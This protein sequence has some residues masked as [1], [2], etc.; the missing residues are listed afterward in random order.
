MKK[1]RAQNAKTVEELAAVKR[2]RDAATEGST[3]KANQILKLRSQIKQLDDQL[4]SYA[5]LNSR[6]EGRDKPDPLRKYKEER[7]TNIL[8]IS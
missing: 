6:G 8:K 2:Q 5:G 3:D 1:E 4:E 7:D